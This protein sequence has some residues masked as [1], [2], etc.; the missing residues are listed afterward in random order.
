[1]SHTPRMQRTRSYE[2]FSQSSGVEIRE[3]AKSRE[4]NGV[5]VERHGR[6]MLRFFKL[7]P[8]TRDNEVTQIRFICEPDEAYALAHLIARVAARDVVCKEKLAPHRFSAGGDDTVTTLTVER[9]ERN[10]KGGFALTV[11]RGNDFI[12]V[13]VPVNKF[14]FAADFLEVLA[15]EQCWVEKLTTTRE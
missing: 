8:K 2:I 9:W 3:A 4:E 1:M 10:G 5:V 12:S 15:V 7:T 13:P 14:C 6:V 11:G